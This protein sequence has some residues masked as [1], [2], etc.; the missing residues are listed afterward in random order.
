MAKMARAGKTEM[1]HILE[2][3]PGASLALGFREPISARAPEGGRTHRGDR[4]PAEL[5]AGAAPAR[6]FFTP[7]HTVHAIGAGL[8]LCEIQQNS[9]RDLPAV[10]LRPAAADPRGDRPC[11]SR[12][13]E[14]I[15]RP[16]SP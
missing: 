15:R 6:R 7:A 3:D 10:G 5:D 16:P 12:I 1:W 14:C 8:V 9:R 4:E 11:R 2:A 13:W